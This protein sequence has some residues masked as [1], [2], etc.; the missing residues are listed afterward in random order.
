MCDDKNLWP[1]SLCQNVRQRHIISRQ[2]ACRKMSLVIIDFTR[3]FRSR[4]WRVSTWRTWCRGTGTSSSASRGRTDS[5]TNWSAIFRDRSHFTINLHIRNR[6]FPNN[7]RVERELLEQCIERRLLNWGTR[8]QILAQLRILMWYMAELG[9]IQYFIWNASFQSIFTSHWL[10]TN[11]W[12]DCNP[13]I[14]KVD[15]TTERI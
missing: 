11:T 5:P 2:N 1:I 10:F 8:V 12:T 13:T 15:E 14:G 6:W 7:Y 4:S 9:P 3:W